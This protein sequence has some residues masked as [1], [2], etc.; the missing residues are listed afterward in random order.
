M[1]LSH[2]RA[3]RTALGILAL[4]FVA[5]CAQA[6]NKPDT[7]AVRVFVQ[8]FYDRYASVQEQADAQAQVLAAKPSFLSAKLQTAL[9]ADSAARFDKPEPTRELLSFDPFLAS[10]DPCPRYRVG[11]VRL[12]GDSARVGVHS[13]CPFKGPDSV[14]PRPAVTVIVY[15]VGSRLEIADFIYGGVTLSRLLC[16]YA[17]ADT[18]Q[19]RRPKSCPRQAP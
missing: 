8:R 15:R 18:R 19:E 7:A 11:A 13:V 17:M 3:G 5:A 14:S 9:R 12:R 2:S 10:Q 6:Q 4:T 1:R 16:Q